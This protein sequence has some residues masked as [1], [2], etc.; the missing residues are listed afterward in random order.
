MSV[1]TRNVYRKRAQHVFSINRIWHICHICQNTLGSRFMFIRI[2]HHLIAFANMYAR[3]TIILKIN[4]SWIWINLVMLLHWL[5]SLL[6]IWKIN[7]SSTFYDK[8]DTAQYANVCFDNICISK[9]LTICIFRT[10]VW[11]PCIHIIL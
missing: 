7:K 8:K 5:L 2:V 6:K 11:L 9:C 10:F 1:G 4:C 3:N